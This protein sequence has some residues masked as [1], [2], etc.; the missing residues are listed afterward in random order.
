V[1]VEKTYPFPS[2]VKRR[3]PWK[4][5]LCC[6]RLT[7]ANVAFSRHFADANPKDD[8]IVPIA[9]S[10]SL[11]VTPSGTSPSLAI[12]LESDVERNQLFCTHTIMSANRCRAGSEQRPSVRD[13]SY[14][15]RRRARG[16][17]MRGGSV[18]LSRFDGH[19]FSAC[20]SLIS[21]SDVMSAIDHTDVD[22]DRSGESRRRRVGRRAANTGGSYERSKGGEI[23]LLYFTLI[24]HELRTPLTILFGSF[25]VA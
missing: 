7:E 14:G 19:R 1:H 16:S 23:R 6:S 8:W 12:E 18:V 15:S 5:S 21:G 25:A 11:K 22:P 3:R 17:F 9:H 2:I 13:P 10:V 20:A 4:I 24:G